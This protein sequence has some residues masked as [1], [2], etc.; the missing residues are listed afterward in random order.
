M[1]INIQSS[2]LLEMLKIISGVINVKKNDI[3]SNI[4]LKK[5]KNK[6]FC[7]AINNNIEIVTFKIINEYTDDKMQEN[8]NFIIKY[9]LIY[10]ICK[11]N[12]NE[13]IINIKNIKN[14]LEISTIN[15]SF[16]IPLIYNNEFPSFK[17]EKENILMIKLNSNDFKQLISY[18]YNTISENNP[19]L[20]LNG[21]L[22]NVNKNSIT[23]ISSD[24]FNLSFSQI[25]N[26][27]NYI[28]TNIKIIIP[29]IIIKEF[30]NLYKENENIFIKISHN[31]IKI[32]TNTITLTSKLINDTY[33]NPIIKLSV[34]NYTKCYIN[35]NEIKNCIT[36]LN[37]LCYNN[38]IINMDIKR[39]KIIIYAKNKSDHGSINIDAKT[40]GNNIKI[41]LNY[42]YII[43]ILKIIK[44][45][46]IELIIPE[47]K[48]FLIIKEK[49][50]N[51]LY[52]ITLL[53]I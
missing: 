29:K 39:D 32:I 24:G 48:K 36:I 20:F 35:T 26:N 38:N 42:K 33:E 5:I 44:E 31:F 51:S 37:T 15:S 18:S 11:S 52:L 16:N 45:N 14:S 47:S 2:I 13:T 40:V 12:K 27:N 34:N 22:F 46:L 9:D 17:I 8:I 50:K 28:D 41:S 30:L 4:L 23:T 25:I 43:N 6:I 19:K 10:N 3:S 7:I 53:K 21:I 49:N 1:E